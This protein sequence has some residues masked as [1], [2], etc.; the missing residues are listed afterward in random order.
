L[1]TAL[2]LGPWQP[3]NPYALS[4][5]MATFPLTSSQAALR[6][7]AR[8]IKQWPVDKVRP[9]FVSFQTIMQKRTNALTSSPESAG[10]VKAGEASVSPPELFNEE[11]E[12]RQV[13]VL[14][15]LLDDKFSKTYPVP[16]NLRYPRSSPSHYDDVIHEMEEAP[17]RSW[18]A[19]FLKKIKGSLRFT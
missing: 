14:S 3:I 7:W 11:R 2:Q 9:E 4:P 12:M 1:Q 15:A 10:R 18:A 6:L 8:I 17:T 16:A 19:S 13:R 5:F